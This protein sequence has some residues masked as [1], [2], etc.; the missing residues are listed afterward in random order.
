MLQGVEDADYPDLGGSSSSSAC[1]TCA[2]SPATQDLLRRAFDG[3]VSLLYTYM[4][5]V[6]PERAVG[7][8]LL[9]FFW[10]G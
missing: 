7:E 9:G 10:G 6:L 3:I 1:T 5:E 2:L 4:Y 8:I